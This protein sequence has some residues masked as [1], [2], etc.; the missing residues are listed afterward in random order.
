[1]SKISS[2]VVQTT[3]LTKKN[4]KL[5]W[6][7]KVSTCV[8]IG[9]GALFLI[10][11]VVLDAA[12]KANSKSDDAFSAVTSRRVVQTNQ[13][14]KCIVGPGKDICYTLVYAPY[15][16][17]LQNAIEIEKV[18]D[19]FTDI[20]KL[21]KKRGAPFGVL[22]LDNATALDSWIIENQNITKSAVIFMN[23]HVWTSP[24]KVPFDYT[25]QSNL[26]VDCAAL[27]VIGCESAF[28]GWVIPVQTGIDSAFIATYGD[29]GLESSARI[30][31][32]FA[33]FP[34]PGFGASFDVVV[35]Y[36]ATFLY[37]AI[38]FNY[39]IQLTLIVQEKELHL[40]ESMTQMGMSKGAYWLSW[41][42]SN[43]IINTIMVFVLMAVGSI[44]QM[45]VFIK[46]DAQLML[47]SLWV[48]SMT[49]TGLAFLFSTLTRRTATARLMGIGIFVLSFIAA[50]IMVGIFFSSADVTYIDW[51]IG[52]SLFPFFGF[53][54]LMDRMIDG[55]SGPG[56]DGLEWNDRLKNILPTD[57]TLETP[58]VWTL[59]ITFSYLVGS[60]F[61]YIVLTWYLDA[62]IPTENGRRQPFYFFLLPSY[63]TGGKQLSSMF[64]PRRLSESGNNSSNPIAGVSLTQQ[65][66]DDLDEDVREETKKVYER[67]FTNRDPAVII[68]NLYKQFG[69]FKA[70]NKVSYAIDNN[71][72]FVILGHNGAGK[73][74]TFNML[75]GLTHV[76]NGDARIFGM[77]IRD[78]MAA[79]HSRMGICPQHDV[80]WDQLTA[81]EHLEMFAKIKGIPEDKISE[82]VNAR[83]KQVNLIGSADYPTRGFSGGMKRRLSISIA[84]IGN[85]S[86]V[87]LDEPTTGMDPVSRREVWDMI[88]AAKKGRVIVLTTHSME[89]ADCLGDRIGVMSHGKL[90]AIGTSL[91][92]KNRFGKGYRLTMFVKNSQD[93][94][95]ATQWVSAN[96]PPGT[97]LASAV[98]GMLLYQLPKQ[99]DST[100]L[101]NFFQ[102]LEGMKSELGISDYSISMTTLEE[103][104]LTLSD[105]D[106]F[107]SN[108]ELVTQ[109]RRSS[110]ILKKQKEKEG[111][112]TLSAAGIPDAGGNSFVLRP[113]A[114]ETQEKKRV[115]IAAQLRALAFKSFTFQCKQKLS[116]CLIVSFPL[117]IMI[118]LL[119]LDVAVLSRTK[120][121]VICGK[122]VSKTECI[123]K[124]LDLECAENLLKLST[125][126]PST[127]TIDVGI[128]ST[129][130]GR[131]VGINAN[132]GPYAC[133][134]G[135]E[136]PDYRDIPLHTNEAIKD[137]VGHQNYSSATDAA[138]NLFEFQ[139]NLYFILQNSSC[140][141]TYNNAFNIEFA[142]EGV[143]DIVACGKDVQNLQIARD[144][145]DSNSGSFGPS[146]VGLSTCQKD[147]E[148]GEIKKPEQTFLDRVTAIKDKRDLCLAEQREVAY[149]LFESVDIIKNLGE[150][151]K[152]SGGVL[153]NYTS[154]AIP[155]SFTSSFESQI[156]QS[157]YS[158]APLPVI[159]GWYAAN[160]KV[161]GLDTVSIA[162]M[163][164]PGSP[165]KSLLNDTLGN[166]I[167][168]LDNICGW[169]TNID[170]VLGIA[171]SMFE[172]A[173]KQDQYFYDSWYGKEVQ[174]QLMKDKSKELSREKSYL[175]RSYYANFH[176]FDFSEADDQSGKYSYTA[177]YNNSAT[178]NSRIGNWRSIV[179]LMD[180]AIVKH[181]TG[182]GIK[183]RTK[184]FPKKFECNRDAWAK[185]ENRTID[186]PSLLGPQLSILD[187]AAT[188]L[189]PY[190]FLLHSFVIV[191]LIVYEKETK[192]LMIMKMMGLESPSYW[193]VTYLWFLVQFLFM[194]LLM[195]ILG[196]FA[197]MN[198]FKLHES[199]VV[200][201]FAFSWANLL[202]AYSFLLSIFFSSSRTSTAA[203]FLMILIFNTVGVEILT[204][205]IQDPFASESQYASFMW[206]PPITMMRVVIWLALSGA[207]KEKILFSELMTYAN[208]A[209]GLTFIY[210]WIEW[211]ACMFLVWYL[212][213]VYVAGFG[214]SYHPL[215]FLQKSFWM[216]KGKDFDADNLSGIPLEDDVIQSG[217]I[218]RMGDDCK[219]EHERVI[220]PGGDALVRIVRLNKRYGNGKLAVKALSLGINK[221][222]CFS[223]LGH[224]GA[225]KTTTINMMC[226]LFEASNGTATVDGYSI[227]T[228]M[229]SIQARSGVCVQEN[230]L[231]DDLSC[232]DH[233]LFF[234]RLKGLTGDELNKAADQALIDVNLKQFEHRRS[235]ALSGGMKRRL[236]VANALIGNPKVV[237]LDEPSTG[238]DPASRR[239]LWD[240]ISRAKGNKS[241]VLTTHSM[242]EAEI[243]ADRVGVMALGELQCVGTPQDLC[244]RFGKGYTLILTISNATQD[245]YDY[246]DKFVKSKFGSAR[247]LEEPIGGTVKYEISRTEVRI[248][249]VFGMFESDEIK[250][251]LNLLNWGITE[252]TL[253]E[254]FL[255]LAEL[256]HVSEELAKAPD[257]QGKF[258]DSKATNI[259]E[260]ND[261]SLIVQ[262]KA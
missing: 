58:P 49:F 35:Q 85:P 46:T 107:I 120:Q 33:D 173:G 239:Q 235:G 15:D 39:V 20:H 250:K 118:A 208:G 127:P 148:S 219:K 198:T 211:F 56:G 53:F 143:T 18:I 81:R 202:I 91:R 105:K 47:T 200:W 38:T 217:F 26:T 156:F 138:K 96:A 76:T 88:A 167:T 234:G 230:I 124:G 188:L 199:S 223:L 109:R 220:T 121:D 23:S 140:T 61:L 108:N 193:I 207:F 57:P 131:R 181:H 62:V 178:R 214:V 79:L 252:T 177:F 144:Y 34:K 36:G 117:F 55:S 191:S 260:P 72:L 9:I 256:A 172:S 168:R 215:F 249:E 40:V 243:L 28:E 11:L 190:I 29:S 48:T 257:Q 183:V 128:I 50:P 90:Q 259:V 159:K 77:S 1:M 152:D 52:T 84:L 70:V 133:F 6:R 75:T 187:F 237:Y 5:Q 197:G 161:F 155:N 169:S 146:S 94:S 196:N 44:L 154:K 229:S 114:V 27:G 185:G 251:Q 212:D 7:N 25:I 244:Y 104:F 22:K 19:S 37:I 32:S 83:L 136:K 93:E 13:N 227:K 24:D 103:V 153:G 30:N 74:T 3:A 195:F 68:E 175:E 14:L 101:V 231:W 194:F 180:N 216:G 102:N 71:Q 189:F 238:L 226:G 182:H 261:Q 255:H 78:D 166:S 165:F 97:S 147:S 145:I 204:V 66:L 205:L 225:G 99:D 201:L 137:V 162:E 186:C 151:T 192:L 100:T 17:N 98:E 142:C 209:I 240:V 95:K 210:M 248:S 10:L 2:F 203:V 150:I 43:T 141:D 67:D 12:I 112:T 224:N 8:Q 21:P 87:F 113:I 134:S 236:S 80:L 115:G 51:R 253:E 106:K 158:R 139:A 129:S 89:E 16:S 262:V 213:K 254:V 206:L 31:A 163:C 73:S 149:K 110:S 4:L 233:V 54:V 176:G 218:E 119:A 132:C 245:G 135:L 242:E 184:S 126:F 246:L 42:I 157:V 116:C 160:G 171:F 41:F 241:I 111:T 221:N 92:L 123:E 170:A 174:T 222:E 232:R 130:Q 258:K 122:G 86:I 65:E 228:D 179:W 82:E 69:S 164:S 247:I 64:S 60:F 59:D 125:S 63:W 45:A